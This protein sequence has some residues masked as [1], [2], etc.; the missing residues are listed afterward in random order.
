MKLRNKKTGEIVELRKHEQI[1]VPIEDKDGDWYE[2]CFDSIAELNGEWEDYVEQTRDYWCIDWDGTL[3]NII[4]LEDGNGVD[5]W[6]EA[7]KEIGNH[8]E[9]REEAVKA[10]EKLKAWKRLNDNGI[11]FS[12]QHNKNVPLP[13]IEIHS[14]EKRATFKKVSAVADDLF[15]I[16][17]D[18][19]E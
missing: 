1:E 17:G 4:V 6:E 7:K 5:E 13:Y 16:F 15:L 14:K 12:L 9:T 10:V 11:Y 2:D 3:K 19:D 8:F 18:K